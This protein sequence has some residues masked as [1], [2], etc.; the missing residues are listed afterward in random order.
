MPFEISNRERETAVIAAETL[1]AIVSDIRIKGYAVVENLISMETRNLLIESVLEDVDR[2][3]AVGQPTEHEKSTGQGHLQLGLRRYA[4]YVRTDIIANPLIE[5][6]V[7]GVLGRGAW[8]GF[9]S[10]NVNCPGSTYQ[11]LHF[12]RPFSWKTQA[13]AVRDGQT[14][15]PPT[16]TLSCSLALEEIT[17]ANGATEIYPGTHLETET[18]DWTQHRVENHPDLI[19]KW[20]PP[21]RMTIPAGSVCFRDPRMW[22]RGVPNPA[23]KPRPM[24]ALTYHAEKSKHWR[25]IYIQDI[26]NETLDQMSRDPA[27]RILDNGELGDGRLIFQSDVREIFDTAPSPYGINRNARFVDLPERVNHFLDAHIIGGARIVRGDIAPD[28]A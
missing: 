9:Y 3:R 2:I 4:P 15:P 23:N 24:I 1:D 7:T 26:A 10:G 8:L 19:A 12:D 6:V 28:G 18:A 27:L 16:T 14:W 13:D 5:C 11:P 25:G 20:A 22:H 17:Q 21:A